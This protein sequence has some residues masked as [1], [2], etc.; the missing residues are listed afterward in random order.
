MDAE[1]ESFIFQSTRELVEELSD[2]PAIEP[3]QGTE[4]VLIKEQTRVVCVPAK[5]DADDVVAMLLSQLLEREG[6]NSE[7]I[8]VGTIGEM[9]SAIEDLT[10]DIVFISALPPF[11]F[12]HAR[13]LYHKLRNRMPKLDIAICVWGYGGDLTRGQARLKTVRGHVLLT[14]LE[15]A[16]RHLHDQIE[17][18]VSVD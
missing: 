10:P 4:S 3:D 11:A 7:S 16:I 14:S 13:T 6:Y 9:L 8:P 17:L 1:T 12:N 18:K 2:L 5:D 15:Q